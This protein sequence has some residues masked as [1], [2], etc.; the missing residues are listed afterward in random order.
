[1]QRKT[2]ILEKKLDGSKLK[3]VLVVSRF[4]SD[5]TEKMLAGSLRALEENSVPKKNIEIVWVPGAFEIPLACQRVA[6]TKKYDGIVTIGCVI[7]GDTDHFYYISS[8]ASHG[9]MRV[10]LDFSIP[11]G[12]GVITTKNL[13]QAQVRSGN[14]NNKGSEA[15]QAVLEMLS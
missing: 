14:K 11:V 7:K 2:R 5:I 4:N 8:E 12:F 6:K 3:I 13:K 15:T 1:M 10:M 9:I